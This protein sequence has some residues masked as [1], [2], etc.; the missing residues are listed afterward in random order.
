LKIHYPLI[1]PVAANLH[2]IFEEGKYADRVIE[3]S[4]KQNPKWGARDRRFIAET[5]YNIVRN[6]RL[7]YESAESKNPWM[8]IAA[9]MLINKLNLPEWKE[10]KG[11]SPE[12]I[13]L[14]Y[15]KKK[16]LFPIAESIPDWLDELGRNELNEI[17]EREVRALNTEAK[18]VLRANT[19]KISAGE[20]KKRF[21][22]LEIETELLKGF[23]EALILK[24]RQNIFSG[25][26]F[27]EGLFEMQD[28]SSQEVGHFMQIEPGM[29][30]VDACA[31]AGG[32]TLHIAALLK[33]KGKIIPCDVEEWKLEELKKRARR[34]GVSNIEPKVID[35]K[36]VKRMEKSA[37]R[38]L[39]DAPCSGLGVLKRNPD[40]KWKLSP[41][42]IE[43]VKKIQ[44][45]ILGEYS[46]MVKPGGKLI[47]ATCSILP[48]ENNAQV[49]KFLDTNKDFV[50]EEEKTLL[51]S[52]GFD[53]FYMARMKRQDQ[54]I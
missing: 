32:K 37:D 35:S 31:G 54:Q 20:L 23:P 13:L 43:K 8:L 15:E 27:K 50:L 53:G 3:R 51:P 24:E 11:I 30:V 39:I 21:E 5:T 28:A 7:L 33:N 44:E 34:A 29:R 46:S 48:S 47:Y 22:K 42:S 2:V 45:Q 38:V 10:L 40:A 16:H 9:Y 1:T 41:A 25:Q 52:E 49:N 4:L 18:V 36:L 14:A 17:W 19:L 6:Y 12:R 26:E